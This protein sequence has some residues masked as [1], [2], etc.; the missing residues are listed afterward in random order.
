MFS[1][2]HSIKDPLFKK[3]RVVEEMRDIGYL[4][5]KLP[6]I[7]IIYIPTG[8]GFRWAWVGRLSYGK[9]KI[10]ESLMPS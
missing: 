6:F 2:E 3:M 1:D 9:G 10:T 4:Q 8:R 5:D 7:I